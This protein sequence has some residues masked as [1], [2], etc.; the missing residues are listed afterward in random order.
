M[1]DGSRKDFK[2]TFN[3][4]D[5]NDMGNL[6]KVARKVC[7]KSRFQYFK[8]INRPATLMLRT[9]VLFYQ[10]LLL[11]SFINYALIIFVMN[12]CTVAAGILA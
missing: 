9:I 1:S 12:S 11:L 6:F 4:T 3:D 5:V 8:N 7:K 2:I 10:F